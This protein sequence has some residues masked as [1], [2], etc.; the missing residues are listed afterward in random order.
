VASN[1]NG[2]YSVVDKSSNDNLKCENLEDQ[3]ITN[4]N[5]DPSGDNNNLNSSSFE[6][7]GS[8]NGL[9]ANNTSGNGF[10][11]KYGKTQHASGGDNPPVV[12]TKN[13]SKL[14][15]AK[16]I[17]E[18]KKF[19]EDQK[20]NSNMFD[21]SDLDNSLQISRRN[22]KE[23]EYKDEMPDTKRSE[24][25]QQAIL[26]DLHNASGTKDDLLKSLQSPN[27]KN[28]DS[29]SVKFSTQEG[30]GT[31]INF[32]ML[33]NLHNQRPPARKKGPTFGLDDRFILKQ[34]GSDKKAA[35]M[36]PIKAQ[37][38]IMR[39]PSRH[40]TPSKALGL[41]LPMNNGASHFPVKNMYAKTQEEIDHAPTPENTN[42]KGDFVDSSSDDG[43]FDE[44]V[45]DNNM[46]FD[47][48]LDL[49]DFLRKD[50]EEKEKERERKEKEREKEIPIDKEKVSPLLAGIQ[51]PGFESDAKRDLKSAH[52]KRMKPQSAQRENKTAQAPRENT[53]S[54]ASVQKE[55]SKLNITQDY[56]SFHL[57]EAENN[58]ADQKLRTIQLD[59]DKPAAKKPEKAA[60]FQNKPAT[61]VPSLQRGSTA[62]PIKRNE[63]LT[64]L[65]LIA[66]GASTQNSHRQ[67]KPTTSY[68]KCMEVDT[69]G[70]HHFTD[71]S[72]NSI[73]ITTSP[74]NKREMTN[75]STRNHAVSAKI[76]VNRT[77]TNSTLN[78]IWTESIM[79]NNFLN[80]SKDKSSIIIT[81]NK[82]SV[83]HKNSNNITLPFETSLGKDFV[84]LF[85]N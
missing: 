6:F 42:Y 20:H 3:R 68:K 37:H 62:N 80:S 74:E 38:N 13:R 14:V 59:T 65:K 63:K 47:N 78:S 17:L 48:V 54:L 44:D 50:K 26:Q 15:L 46:D 34:E 73:H 7:G 69:D 5:N 28:D 27:N 83:L 36:I 31:D 41:D 30:D 24:R 39:P 77:P 70:I 85:A 55:D 12:G 21:L 43:I 23:H 52:G 81:H 1:N 57:D 66:D 32:D 75:L 11:E 58:N 9:N 71:R 40:R 33:S 22:I 53:P 29:S 10:V 2:R 45:D 79:K 56:S 4:E 67:V 61:A 72:N 35:N 25:R 49:S 18:P 82:S 60:L 51:H 84:S 8:S 64:A 76:P 16:K 19:Q